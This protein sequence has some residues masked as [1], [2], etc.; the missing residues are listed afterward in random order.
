MSS[1][2]E[3]FTLIEASAKGAKVLGI[4][5]SGDKINL[6]WKY[7]A[8]IDLSAMQIPEKIPLLANHDNKTGSRIGMITAKVENNSLI[9]EGQVL[10]ESF[11]ANEIVN[12]IKSGGNWQLSIG[13]DVVENNTIEAGKKI[14]INGRI[15]DGEIEHVT[16]S[17]LREVSVV[18]VGAD[19]NTELKIAAAYIVNTNFN[20][21][22]VS[23]KISAKGELMS[24]EEDVKANVVK[25]V[26][27]E[28]VKIEAKSNVTEID[29][30]GQVRAEHK[31]I[32]QVKAACNGYPEIE[33]KAISDGLS[34][35]EAKAMILDVLSTRKGSE[36][37]ASYVNTGAGAATGNEVIEAAAVMATG[38]VKNGRL[39][40]HYDEK[41]LDAADKF[42]RVGLK[43]MIRIVAANEGKRIDAGVS[44]SILASAGFSTVSLPK[45]LGNIANKALLD[46][47]Q[48]RTS[49]AG[50]LCENLSA[51]NF[52]EH[53]G[54][55]LG[56]MGRMETV[57]NGGPIK[58]GSMTEE[59]FT[60]RI[61]TVAMIIGLTR[62]MIAND[63][64]GGFVRLARNLGRSAFNTL[65]FDFWA[66]VLA[67]TDSFFNASNSNLITDALSVDGVAEAVATLAEQ[68]GIDG[69]PINISGNWLVIPPQLEGTAR[70]IF[71]SNFVQGSTSK[72]PNANVYMNVYEPAMSPYLSNSNV[73]ANASETAWY[74]WSQDVKPFGVAYL[75]GVQNPVVEEVD[76]GAEYLGRAYRA[77]M[78]YGVCQVD[79]R[80]AVMSTGAGS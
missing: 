45:M 78:D 26:K 49:L 43:E 59:Y 13:A 76:P 30:V 47:Y 21:E 29:F 25:D 67:N 55:K 69:T 77:Y 71:A 9:I 10:S 48:S 34:V 57:Q 23:Q 68:T 7:P 12:Q 50:I 8:V 80:G 54:I 64:L 44:E 18:A 3:L 36:I 33:E 5:Y 46:E 62:E 72:T 40:A 22:N 38:A 70:A 27:Q 60:Y 32:S 41:V 52:H 31:R 14:E 66:L 63:D 51:N 16:R 20:N 56:G 39:E 17:V 37:N 6:G 73:S 65:E 42:R 61:N 75:N 24:T 74:L 28:D 1:K 19:V 15:F 35:I 2:E 11:I 79:S 58:H 53:T 4:A